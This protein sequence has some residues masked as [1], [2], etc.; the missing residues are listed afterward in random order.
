M[1]KTKVTPNNKPST[2]LNAARA[3]NDISIMQKQRLDDPDDVV[4]MNVSMQ[5]EAHGAET[6][7]SIP[8]EPISKDAIETEKEEIE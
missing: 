1:E 4:S 7:K 2:V 5:D 8:V 6:K 3:T